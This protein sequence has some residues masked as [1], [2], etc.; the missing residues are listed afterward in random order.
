MSW[1]YYL[2]I[3]VY[4]CNIYVYSILH[5]ILTKSQFMVQPSPVVGVRHTTLACRIS[6]ALVFNEVNLHC[7]MYDTINQPCWVFVD[8]KSCSGL[9]SISHAL[10]FQTFSIFF[11]TDLGTIAPPEAALAWV[12]DPECYCDKRW[13]QSRLLLQDAEGRERNGWKPKDI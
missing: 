5:E 10:Y 4:S 6:F 8:A 13:S 2:F 1:L 3:H 7:S 11:H 9:F 12:L